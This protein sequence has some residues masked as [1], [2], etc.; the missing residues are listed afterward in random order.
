MGGFVRTIIFFTRFIVLLGVFTSIILASEPG[1]VAI[2]PANLRSG[3]GTE[4]PVIGK[5]SLG[6]EFMLLKEQNDW[7]QV[8][9]S[10]Q[11]AW[12]LA[13]LGVASNDSAYL[14]RVLITADA[15]LLYPSKKGGGARKFARTGEIARFISADVTS[16]RISLA[17]GTS[18]KIRDDFVVRIGPRSQAKGMAGL[19]LSESGL[20]Q[21]ALKALDQLGQRNT[22]FHI[23][24][25]ILSIVIFLLPLALISVLS[26][27]IEAIKWL[28]NLIV[29][30][31]V[32]FISVSIMGIF[33]S[34]FVIS[35]LIPVWG[36]LIFIL[37]SVS[38]LFMEWR[39]IN[40]NRCPRCHSMWM[41][42][43]RGTRNQGTWIWKTVS[44]GV[45]VKSETHYADDRHC[46]R[47]GYN[48]SRKRVR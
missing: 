21:R 1:V 11:T 13:S 26:S 9:D 36:A 4:Y 32:F 7:F 16:Y 42:E 19:L 22:F 44:K 35:S 37:L 41:A 30:F 28:P 34:A 25:I 15:E 38:Q 45:V 14:D 31:L 12:L 27:W 24:V 3:P 10:E 20:F 43:D 47:C 23:L 5:A 40:Y 33:S 18:A 29:K 48:W 46:Q 39:E 17:D 2:K 6:D 8:K